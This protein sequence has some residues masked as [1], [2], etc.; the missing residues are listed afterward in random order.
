VRQFGRDYAEVLAKAGFKVDAD[1]L[2]FEISENQRERM[3]LARPGEELI[4]RV[5]KL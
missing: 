3:R 1:R 2:Y 5:V 4:Y